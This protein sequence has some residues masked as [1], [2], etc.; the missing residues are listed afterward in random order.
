MWWVI[1]GLHSRCTRRTNIERLATLVSKDFAR[2]SALLRRSEGADPLSSAAARSLS[3]AAVGLSPP[4]TVAPAPFD[5]SPAKGIVF[6]ASR[7]SRSIHRDCSE[8]G[9]DNEN[10]P[11]RVLMRLYLYRRNRLESGLRS[12]LELVKHNHDV[13]G[14]CVSASYYVASPCRYVL[15]VS[16]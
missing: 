1:K 13:V 2:H 5:A 7:S 8:E 10:Q 4:P 9:I 14:D 3:S 11:W 16:C 6:G 15:I 12:G